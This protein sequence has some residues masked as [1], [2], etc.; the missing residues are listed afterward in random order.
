MKAVNE[1][2]RLPVTFKLFDGD[3]AARTPTTLRY[4]VDCESTGRELIGWT[5]LTPASEVSLIV[6]ATVNAIQNRSN[7]FELKTMT[8]EADTGT[9]NAFTEEYTWRVNNL[10]GV[11]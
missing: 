6:P 5:D 4:R 11:S 7:S 9:V 1:G 10:Q 8:V 3:S 2:S